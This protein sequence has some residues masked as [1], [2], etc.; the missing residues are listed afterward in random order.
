MSRK[1]LSIFLIVLIILPAFVHA[2][3]KEYQRI[4]QIPVSQ[5][6]NYTSHVEDFR[7]TL[8]K[9][10]SAFK[11]GIYLG[12]HLP[13]AEYSLSYQ[14]DVMIE[15]N[16]T[17]DFNMFVYGASDYY[18]YI[19]ILNPEGNI[20]M[21][22]RIDNFTF[23]DDDYF[24]YGGWNRDGM[25]FSA[26]AEHNLIYY[27]PNIG[28]ILHNT[29]YPL[30]SEIPHTLQISIHCF[31]NE[32]IRLLLSQEETS[33]NSTIAVGTYFYRQDYSDLQVTNSI[34]GIP[35]AMAFLAT[36]GLTQF[37]LGAVELPGDLGLYINYLSSVGGKYATLDMP[38]HFAKPDWV[39]INYTWDAPSGGYN[40][41]ITAFVKNFIIQST[42]TLLATPATGSYVGANFTVY[43][44]YSKNYIVFVSTQKQNLNVAIY[45]C[46]T[47]K[48]W[49]YYDYGN[50][51]VARIKLTDDRYVALNSSTWT[52]SRAQFAKM[53]LQNAVLLQYYDLE[54]HTKGPLATEIVYMANLLEAKELIVSGARQ[55]KSNYVGFTTYLNLFKDKLESFGKIIWQTLL[56]F[57]G[58]ITREIMLFWSWIAPVLQL[59]LYFIFVLGVMFLMKYLSKILARGDA[60]ATA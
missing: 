57:W 25:N 43:P 60:N 18:I 16:F 11:Y 13:P 7:I 53:A 19:P 36:E 45:D 28:Y 32:P 27:L 38:Y 49:K 37:G 52:I 44:E 59:A 39:V 2:E 46:T 5:N 34:S 22:I 51:I 6:Y 33:L 17:L 10:V 30:Q 55:L 54:E 21:H 3:E 50:Y 26:L 23:L 14:G 20:A 58:Y 9:Y 4:E 31:T 35:I 1:L 40:K 42:D 24:A 47:K 56:K 15:I 48:I 8:G 12:P 41:Q 29:F